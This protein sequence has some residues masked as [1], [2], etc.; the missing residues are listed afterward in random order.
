MNEKQSVKEK[1]IF[2]ETVCAIYLCYTI[3]IY[4]YIV[5]EA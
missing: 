3:Y 1:L 5:H 2:K 4:I